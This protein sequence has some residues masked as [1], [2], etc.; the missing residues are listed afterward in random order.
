MEEGRKNRPN[1]IHLHTNFSARLQQKSHWFFWID[2]QI[3]F[4]FFTNSYGVGVIG[5]WLYVYF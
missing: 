4:S 5:V 3:Q 1:T 2:H